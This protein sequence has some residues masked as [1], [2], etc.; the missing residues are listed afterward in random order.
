MNVESG[1]DER[2]QD[3]KQT[4][5]DADSGHAAADWRGQQ[6]RSKRDDG[7]EPENRSPASPQTAATRNVCVYGQAPGTTVRVECMKPCRRPYLFSVA[8]AWRRLRAVQRF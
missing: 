1:Q 7:D 5:W 2:R 3:H 6:L 4:D 8:G